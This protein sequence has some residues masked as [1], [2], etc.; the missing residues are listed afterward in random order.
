MNQLLNRKVEISNALNGETY[1]LCPFHQID[2]T[3]Q[4]L[5][6][7][8]SICNEPLVYRW[9]FRKLCEGQPYPTEMAS[10]WLKLST[11]GWKNDTHYVYVVTDSAGQIAAACD[12]KSSNLDRAE[13]G[14]WS[15]AYHRGIMMNSVRAMIQLAD[16]AG[17]RVLFADIHPEN[18]RSLA[19]IQRCDFD[20]VQRKPSI[21]G[22]LSFDRI[23]PLST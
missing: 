7:I 18:E 23:S 16:E 17:F 15:S 5:K 13:V 20:K 1:L 12:I 22:H 19:V 21:P 9:C 11:E 10:D 6:T 4:T 14:Y 3:P 2:A 8:A